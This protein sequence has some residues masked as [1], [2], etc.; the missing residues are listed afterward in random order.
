MPT[1]PPLIKDIIEGSIRLVLL[2]VIGWLGRHDIVIN[3]DAASIA[4]AITF[5]V[6]FAWMVWSKIKKYRLKNTQSA[7]PVHATEDDAA[8]VMKE[9]AW[10]S[11][12]TQANE[13]P[14]ITQNKPPVAPGAAQPII[15]IETKD[16][17]PSDPGAGQP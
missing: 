2:W 14:V 4:Q 5:I 13:T 3:A 8:K 11:A 16:Q 15:V 9:G 17:P 7:L 12:L 10:A 1:V 6:L